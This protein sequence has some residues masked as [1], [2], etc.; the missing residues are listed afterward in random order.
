MHGK[1][2]GHKAHL[3][4]SEVQLKAS[5][6]RRMM[7]GDTNLH[8][9]TPLRSWHLQPHRIPI[10]A[11]A[12]AWQLVHLPSHAAA[13]QQAMHIVTLSPSSPLP[14]LS[15]PPAVPEASHSL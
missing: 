8:L 3:Y 4:L 1:A 12:T 14:S 9:S 11:V 7:H 13:S 2:T 6:K 15:T 10:Q 5:N